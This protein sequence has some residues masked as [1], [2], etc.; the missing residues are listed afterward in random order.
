MKNEH[1]N[2]AALNKKILIFLKSLKNIYSN[3]GKKHNRKHSVFD[4]E[5]NRAA[6]IF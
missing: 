4:N 2:K 3:D 5:K 1:F 6:G